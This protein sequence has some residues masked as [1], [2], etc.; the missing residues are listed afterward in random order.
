ME[1]P[2]ETG[3][4]AHPLFQAQ[5]E[6][7]AARVERLAS[8]GPKGYSSHAAAMLLATIHHYVREA[9]PRDP[10]SPEI[11]QGNTLGPDKR[12]WL[13]AKFHGSR[14]LLRLQSDARKRR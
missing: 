6:K 10:H 14:T 13:R 4:F 11:R 7:L 5:L 2:A 3:W 1:S 12:H 9:I 8:K